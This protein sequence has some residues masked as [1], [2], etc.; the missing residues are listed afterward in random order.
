MRL[1]TR[2]RVRTVISVV[3]L[4]ALAFGIPA[5]RMNHRRRDRLLQ[6]AA[7]Q[8]DRAAWHLSLAAANCLS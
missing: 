4:V 2:F 6:A 7:W 3:A 5:E 1:P 8:L